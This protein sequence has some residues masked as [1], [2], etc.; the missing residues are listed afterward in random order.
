MRLLW[1]KAMFWTG[2]IKPFRAKCLLGWKRSRCW[3]PKA[4]G[5][6]I[7]SNMVNFLANLPSVDNVIFSQLWYYQIC[8]P[9]AF[10]CGQMMLKFGTWLMSNPPLVY[11]RFKNSYLVYSHT[12]Q[13]AILT[14]TCPVCLL[15]GFLW[16][17]ALKIVPI[18]WFDSRC[19]Y[20]NKS[21]G[22]N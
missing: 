4:G 19:W 6:L 5:T 8:F 12:P 2:L 16:S 20:V 11:F 15:T 22:L 10:I 18:I 14:K 17:F 13:S 1:S 9:S 7:L 3:T 21:I